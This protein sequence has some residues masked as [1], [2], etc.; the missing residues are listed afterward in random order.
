MADATLARV[1]RG[2][3]K[4]QATLKWERSK[5]PFG[6]DLRANET[7]VALGHEADDFWEAATEKINAL[8]VEIP[9]V[10]RG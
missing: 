7:R 8:H 1:R 6:N 2:E 3:P 4:E 9:S 5:H 10:A